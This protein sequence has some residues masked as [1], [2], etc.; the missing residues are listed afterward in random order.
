M[1][2]PGAASQR[3]TRGGHE[4]ATGREPG[5]AR[6][7]RR[8]AHGWALARAERGRR[9]PLGAA[10]PGRFGAQASTIRP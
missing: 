8:G 3:T 4:A 5:G 7:Q 6:R 9:G 1:C 2:A 10:R